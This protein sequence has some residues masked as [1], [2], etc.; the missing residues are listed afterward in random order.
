MEQARAA[1]GARGPCLRF[2][3]DEQSVGV[4]D[5]F[6]GP[7]HIDVRRLGDFVIAKSDGSPAYHLAVVVDDADMNVT[8]VVR[9]DDLLES[10]GRQ[11]LL[12]RALGVGNKIPRYW[13]L[14]LVVGSDGRRLAKRHG[15]TRLDYYRRRGVA[16]ERVVALLARWCGIDAGEETSAA[17]LRGKLDWDRLPRHPIVFTDAND[18]FL[19]RRGQIR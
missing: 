1:A 6:R 9:G 19:L 3:V 4:D 18:A 10:A 2:A 12:Y 16:P 14:P 7:R 15:D 8:D 17:D 5:S 13:H 11:I